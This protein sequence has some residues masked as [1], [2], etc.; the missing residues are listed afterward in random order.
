M[1]SIEVTPNNRKVDFTVTLANATGR[2]FHWSLEGEGFT[3]ACVVGEKASGVDRI[4]SRKVIPII[5]KDNRAIKDL[6]NFKMI[7]RENGPTGSI[8]ARSALVVVTVIKPVG[9]IG[10]IPIS[11]PFNSDGRPSWAVDEG[12]WE[13][14]IED[15]DPGAVKESLDQNGYLKGERFF[16]KNGVTTDGEGGTWSHYHMMS[17]DPVTGAMTYDRSYFNATADMIMQTFSRDPKDDIGGV[18]EELNQLRNRSCVLPFVLDKNIYQNGEVVGQR[19]F[20]KLDLVVEL[21]VLGLEEFADKW[22]NDPVWGHRAY[23]GFTGTSIDCSLY[24]NVTPVS[25]SPLVEDLVSSAPTLQNTLVE[26]YKN[27]GRGYIHIP[28]YRLSNYSMNDGFEPIV[29]QQRKGFNARCQL[30]IKDRTTG[31]VVSGLMFS[32]IQNSILTDDLNIMTDNWAKSNLRY[33]FGDVIRV[34]EITPLYWQEPQRWVACDYTPDPEV[35]E[36]NIYTIGYAGY[37]AGDE[38]EFNPVVGVDPGAEYFSTPELAPMMVY[39]GMTYKN[40]TNPN[41]V[42]LAVLHL[43]M[44]PQKLGDEFYPPLDTTKIKF[45]H[46]SGYVDLGGE[47][48]TDNEINRWK[49]VRQ[50]LTNNKLFSIELMPNDFMI[51]KPLRKSGVMDEVLSTTIVVDYGNGTYNG[52]YADVTL[53]PSGYRIRTTGSF[54]FTQDIT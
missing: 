33:I 13:L 26:Y 36:N 39:S 40:L 38:Y 8:V 37:T 14:T 15:T 42:E 4:D 41:D 35:E 47:G 34:S 24:K 21:R 32:V 53:L 12:Q 2:D 45:Y 10:L 19:D 25:G 16:D 51:L 49:D 17:L 6:K 7:I 27:E 31:E 30:T 54:P 44:R 46:Y 50:D 29:R 3:A 20:S 48:P 52:I 18:I 9:K 22:H 1:A 43:L 11:V 5:L 23:A 28:I